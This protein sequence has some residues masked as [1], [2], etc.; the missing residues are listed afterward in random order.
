MHAGRRGFT[1][2][3]ILVVVM[4]VAALAAV[5]VP[6]LA[7]SKEA[8]RVGKCASN[9][10]QL[11]AALLLYAGDWGAVPGGAREIVLGNSMR[12]RT[13]DKAIWSYIK[14]RKVFHCPSDCTKGDRSYA[15]NDQQCYQLASSGP[16]VPG[17]RLS[18][19]SHP[20]KFVMLTEMHNDINR[21]FTGCWVSVVH[22]HEGYHH[23][24]K[25]SNEAFFDGHVRYY[26]DGE[27]K[28]SSF[29]YLKE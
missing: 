26:K 22:P 6:V 4:I 13:W 24:G 7:R 20:E 23:G 2:V 28:L 19:V 21:M 9:E 8:G 3:E 18:Q 12:L 29:L 17:T 27:I 5:L 11:A 15:L 1:L 14:T 16:D 10:H 25:G